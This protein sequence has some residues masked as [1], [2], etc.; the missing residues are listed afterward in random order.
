MG[1]K[2]K[3][4]KKLQGLDTFV[5]QRLGQKKRERERDRKRDKLN[6][7]ENSSKKWMYPNRLKNKNKQRVY[8]GLSLAK[9]VCEQ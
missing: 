2:K 4:K 3:I 5:A 1:K 6:K 9:M 7:I 8:R